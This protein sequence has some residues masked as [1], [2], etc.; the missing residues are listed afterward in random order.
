MEE[1]YLIL[2]ACNIGIS[3]EIASCKAELGGTKQAIALVPT[4]EEVA[5]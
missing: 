2:Q 3:T 4:L 1:G 5:W